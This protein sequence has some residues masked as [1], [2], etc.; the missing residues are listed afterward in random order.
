MGTIDQ[1]TVASLAIEL[2]GLAAAGICSQVTTSAADAILN[3]LAEGENLR[4]T[5]RKQAAA[6]HAGM[7]AAKRASSI[8][9]ALA[10]QARAESAPEVLASER[11]ANALLSSE[12]EQLENNLAHSNNER[13]LWQSR[14]EKLRR[15]TPTQ[16]SDLLTKH[17][18]GVPFEQLVDDLPLHVGER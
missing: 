16:F 11:A 14:Y 18:V 7:D 10:E 8:Q 1:E 6:A 13:S 2:R 17:Q 3:L 4:E 12:V 15:L 5:I 9:L